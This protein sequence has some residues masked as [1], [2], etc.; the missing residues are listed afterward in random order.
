MYASISSLPSIKNLLPP[1]LLGGTSITLSIFFFSPAASL[2]SKTLWCCIGDFSENLSMKHFSDILCHLSICPLSSVGGEWR[3]QRWGT[4]NALVVCLF[5]C[6]G[7]FV[8]LCLVV[9]FRY[10]LFWLVVF[11]VHDLGEKVIVS[12]MKIVETSTRMRN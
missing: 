7:C 4:T 8:L 9:W 3:D 2:G 6:F 12:P 1:K 10:F 5:C 11:C